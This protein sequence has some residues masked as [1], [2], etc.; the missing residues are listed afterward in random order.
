MKNSLKLATAVAGIGLMAFGAGTAQADPS[1]TPTYRQLAGVGSDTTQGVMNAMSNAITING[2]KVIGSYDATGSATIATQSGAACQ[3]VARPNGSGAGRTALLNSL[4]AADGC[5][6]FS[7]SSSLNTTASI[8]GLT[9]VPYAIDAVTYAITPKSSI[10]RNLSLADL[11]SIYTCDPN[12][13]GT[14]PN[15]SIHA[16]LPQAGSG[17]RSFWE[18][19]VGISDTDVVSGKYPCI[20]DTKNG[21]PIEEHDGR[22]LDDTSI[23]PFSIAQYIAQESGTITDLRG[24]ALLGNIDGTPSLLLNTGAT[25][26]REVYNVIPSSKVGTAPYSTVFVGGTSLICQQTS[27]IKNYG[28]GLDANCG[29]TSKTSG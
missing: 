21:K 7:R 16:L 3:A 6:Q 27:I 26:T 12:Y 20:S 10:P 5:L 1:G 22:V 28:F 14:A 18:T 2:T 17:T 23:A 24:S 9:Y 29:D 13:V 11:H 15:Y 4:T 8:P 25:A 19:T